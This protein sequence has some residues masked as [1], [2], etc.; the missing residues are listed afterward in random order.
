MTPAQAAELIKVL[1]EIVS[2]LHGI[3]AI[4]AVIAIGV[5]LS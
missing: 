1:G 4:L 5:W 2:V 3:A